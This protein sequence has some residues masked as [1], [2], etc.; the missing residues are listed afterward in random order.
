QRDQLPVPNGYEEVLQPDFFAE[1]DQLCFAIMEVKKPNATM[2]DIEDD[3]RKL[4]CMM[5]I[6]LNMLIHGN[7]QNATVVG[8][9]VNENICEVFAMNL[10][11]EAIY[12]PKSLGRFKLPQDRLDITSLLLALGPLTAAKNI[13]SNMV[14]SIKKRSHLGA[15]KYSPLTRPS[16]Y[17]FGSNVPS[18]GL[19]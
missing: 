10:E 1:V 7:V 9:L 18:D 16:Y 8:F 3:V 14:T 17:V 15:G 12:I 4:P 5:K 13:A 2:D 6:A 11:H 19:V